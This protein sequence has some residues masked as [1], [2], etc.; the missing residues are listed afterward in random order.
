MDIATISS[1]CLA[2]SEKTHFMDDHSR[3]WKPWR[4]LL[5]VKPYMTILHTV[6]LTVSS[7]ASRVWLLTVK[8]I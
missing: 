8:Q 1:N 5:I 3:R 7:R 4:P 6:R 2:V